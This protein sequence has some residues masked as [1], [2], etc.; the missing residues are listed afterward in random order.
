MT[1][2]SYQTSAEALAKMDVWK[3]RS[4]GAG[5]VGLLLCAIG[6]FLN[7]DQF[8]R[9]Y[10]IGY[11]FWTGLSLGCMAVLMLQYLT[12]GAWGVM[13]RRVCEAGARTLP[14]AFLLFI[15]IALGVKNLYIWARPEVMASDPILQQKAAYLNIPGFLLRWVIYF[16]IWIF[17]TWRMTGWGRKQDEGGAEPWHT[18]LQRWAGPGVLIY[19]LTSTFAAID[20]MMSLDPHWYS[21]IYGIL[22]IGGQG[23]STM[24]LAIVVLVSLADTGP[25]NEAIT[26]KHLHDLGKLMFAFV[27]LWAYFG[28]SQFIITWAANLPEEITWYM[29]R[30]RGGWQYIAIGLV[31]FHFALPFAILLSRRVKQNFHR[32]R[33]IAIFLLVMRLVDLYFLMGPQAHGTETSAVH[34]HWLDF[35]APIGIGGIWLF[36]YF[37]QLK[38]RPLLPLHDPML[39]EAIQH[40]RHH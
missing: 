24:A 39:E 8:F 9:S 32:I 17:L 2:L 33:M 14:V 15:P 19:G 34:L 11:M 7:P 31:V 12:G 25:M 16:A 22:F 40:G 18:R 37:T 3:S 28:F 35:V 23:L 1:T 26:P 36:A 10:L 27:M 5:V 29:S 30:W 21:T 6:W 13:I 20:W 4:L 38:Q